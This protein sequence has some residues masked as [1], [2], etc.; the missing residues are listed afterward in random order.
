MDINPGESVRRIPILPLSNSR[1]GFGQLPQFK[2]D[3]EDLVSHWEAAVRLM[4][5][6]SSSEG[7]GLGLKR[8]KR[9]LGIKDKNVFEG[10][11]PAEDP[12][13]YGYE[14]SGERTSVEGDLVYSSEEDDPNDYE[15][16]NSDNDEY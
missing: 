13:D 4:E 9:I 5:Q 15:E 11:N 6:L 2:Q 16:L 1:S 14:Q 7:S 8:K 12:L 3:Y 10:K